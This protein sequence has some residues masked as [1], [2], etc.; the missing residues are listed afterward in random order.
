M[1]FTLFWKRPRGIYE[2]DIMYFFSNSIAYCTRSLNDQGVYTKAQT[3]RFKKSYFNR[4]VNIEFPITKCG[5]TTDL[6]TFIKDTDQMLDVYLTRHLQET[7]L[8]RSIF[9]CFFLTLQATF[10]LN[11][12]ILH[13]F[14]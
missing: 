4:V 7:A 11:C 3:G 1:Y 2:I 10:K 5:T 9:S 14:F 13:R 8:C 12:D 6:K